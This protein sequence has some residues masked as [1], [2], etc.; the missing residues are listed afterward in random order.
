MTRGDCFLSCV[1]LFFA[2]FV[3]VVCGKICRVLRKKMKN[4]VYLYGNHAVKSA[5]S[6]KSRKHFALYCVGEC[7]QE[8]ARYSFL[9]K[10]VT[11]QELD[12][13]VPGAVHQ[14]LVL[15]TSRL[16]PVHLQ[17]LPIYE[18]ECLLV[19]FDQ[20]T[21][22]HNVGAILRSGA[23][24]GV[25]G[26]IYTDR[27]Y[28]GES[29]VLAKSASGALELIPSACVVNLVRS[30]EELKQKGFWIIGLSEHG[31]CSLE[32]ADLPKKLVVVIGAEGTGMRK[33]VQEHCDFLVSL[34]TNPNFP[35][36]NASTAASVCLYAIRQKIPLKN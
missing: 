26:V 13:L 31:N 1:K 32:T 15:E 5:L 21:D 18:E 12:K 11:K 33:L 10:K 7:P 14:G 8:F 35:T 24:F 34:P 30:L 19:A 20:L 16:V 25:D 3:G 17:D 6:N 4:K 23:C 36:L 2:Y 29:G 9:Y 22:P 28:P 27:N